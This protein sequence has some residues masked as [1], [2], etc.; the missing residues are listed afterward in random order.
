MDADPS[1][2]IEKCRLTSF[3]TSSIPIY[4]IYDNEKTLTSGNYFSPGNTEVRYDHDSQ[5]CLSK[6]VVV[7]NLVLGDTLLAE[8]TYEGN[9]LKTLKQYGRQYD[10]NGGPSK[11]SIMNCKLYYNQSDLPDSMQ[12]INSLLDSTGKEHNSEPLRLD[13]F[14]FDGGDN[15]TKQETYIEDVNTRYVLVA[16][17][18]HTYDNKP[19]YLKKLKQIYFLI[20][21][22]I[23]YMF[24]KNNLLSTR[25]ESPG[26]P[27]WEISY[28]ITYDGDLVKNDGMRFSEM[29]WSCD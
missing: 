27:S 16:S 5:R 22:S 1:K 19:N 7:G 29:K 15:L 11:K 6:V 23:P 13:R 8:Y 3:V 20:D 26:K 28:E 9:R 10:I 18:Y 4:M 12:V 17:R 21:Q 24:S 14:F 2:Q 25:H